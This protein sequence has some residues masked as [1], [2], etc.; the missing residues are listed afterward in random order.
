MQINQETTN[1]HSNALERRIDMSVAVA[2]IDKDVGVRLKKLSR[3]VKMPGFRPGKVPLQVV[4]RTYEPQVRSE[5]I[6]AAV[7]KAFGEAV[8]SQ[9]LR[10][11]GHPRIEPKE[12]SAA[13]VLEFSVVFEVY[14]DVVIGD[15][16][17]RDIER[18][19]LEVREA[20]VD[21]TIDVLRKQ[22]TRYEPADRAAAA[23]DRVVIDFA[24][25]KAGELFEGGQA[26]E[27]PFVLGAG[28]MLKEFDAAVDGM[29]E[30]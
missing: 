3:S 27:F 11:A 12:I 20:E 23:G 2:D 16:S 26:L 19:R 9:N 10:V 1:T 30:G 13:G 14:P 25:R 6:G 7:E 24:G 5:A 21:R 8:R 22:R 28:T 4:A 18:S 15:L 17:T 29:K